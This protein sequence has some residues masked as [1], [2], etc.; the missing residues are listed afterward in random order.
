[1]SRGRVRSRADHSLA[2]NMFSRSH[3]LSSSLVARLGI[4]SRS[5][6]GDSGVL[7]SPAVVS[8]VISSRS[9]EQA[10][11]FFSNLLLDSADSLI[12][13]R[14]AVLNRVYR[15]SRADARSRL[16]KLLE[17]LPLRYQGIHKLASQSIGRAAQAGQGDP[18]LRL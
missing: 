11:G 17:T 16:L 9:S 18:R 12:F 15:V 1:M 10:F 3:S 5:S 8:I 14:H 13:Q 7:P 2:R 4:S 6:S